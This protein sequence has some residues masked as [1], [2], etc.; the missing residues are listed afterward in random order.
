MKG[1]TLSVGHQ[2]ASA[3]LCQMPRF[4]QC[5]GLREAALQ[6]G[7]PC[8][9]GSALVLCCHA[10]KLQWFTAHCVWGAPHCQ[11]LPATPCT[12]G[13]SL[14]PRVRRPTAGP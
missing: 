7:T 3:L 8:P 4:R 10:W 6:L 14:P 12:E 1:R 2:E 11:Y 9:R 13:W 5:G